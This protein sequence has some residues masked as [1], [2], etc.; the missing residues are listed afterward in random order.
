[1]IEQK[2]NQQKQ[3]QSLQNKIENLEL[4][5]R[6]TQKDVQITQ[7]PKIGSLNDLLIVDSHLSHIE[8]NHENTNKYILYCN[9]CCDTPTTDGTTFRKGK[10]VNKNIEKKDLQVLY[11][12]WKE[13]IITCTHLHN[14]TTHH[15][16]QIQI[17]NRL[18]RIAYGTICS[19]DADSRC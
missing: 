10:L 17:F 1:M 6:K 16:I 2:N 18:N 5:I 7:H 4:E 15:P 3:I 11:Q 14:E 12:R 8:I 13:H 19:G 9:C